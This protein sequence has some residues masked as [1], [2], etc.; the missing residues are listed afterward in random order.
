MSSPYFSPN[1][2]IQGVVE[3]DGIPFPPEV[4]PSTPMRVNA[5][6]SSTGNDYTNPPLLQASDINVTTGGAA[7][8][9]I[10]MNTAAGAIPTATGFG[11]NT[12]TKLLAMI[13]A[14]TGLPS[15]QSIQVYNATGGNTLIQ[16]TSTVAGD[17]AAILKERSSNNSV[18]VS[19]YQ[20]IMA[21]GTT[22]ATIS[23]DTTNGAIVDPGSGML[24]VRDGTTSGTSGQLLTADGSGHC[25]WQ[26]YV[27]SGIKYNQHFQIGW[28]AFGNSVGANAV[29]TPS[30][31]IYADYWE[32]PGTKDNNQLFGTA[33]FSVGQAG[34]YQISIQFGQGATNGIMDVTIDGVSIGTM[35]GYIA[36]GGN[37]QFFP[38][39]PTLAAGDHT[40]GL[41][42]TTKNGASGGYGFQAWGYGI[43]FDIISLV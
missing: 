27:P 32:N 37:R 35:D 22:N 4:T 34:V 8:R 36:S 17:G 28:F 33:F 43:Q 1:G 23:V 10:D 16:A 24:T 11:Y 20:A 29:L 14:D 38:P 40:I 5:V 39:S 19:K 31:D 2:G 9:G 6:V 3:I 7:Q 30:S 18:T 13:A 26:T 12:T 21:V 42:I 15:A 41:S 25:S